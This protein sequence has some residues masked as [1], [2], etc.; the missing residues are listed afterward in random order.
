MQP[1]TARK[2]G[3]RKSSGNPFDSWRRERD[4]NPC[5]HSCITRFRIVR[6]RP[7]RHL[8]IV[9][10]IYYPKKKSNSFLYIFQRNSLYNG[11]VSIQSDF[12]NFSLPFNNSENKKAFTKSEG[13]F[14][15]SLNKIEFRVTIIQSYHHFA[16]R[17]IQTLPSYRLRK[18]YKFK[19][20]TL[21][22]AALPPHPLHWLFVG[23]GEVLRP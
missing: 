4:L 12:I 22:C 3:F 19:T 2:K 14:K 11:R 21:L 18:K 23:Y 17:T 20:P 8:C 9:S 7:L 6:V 1:K 16:S 5:M 15:S 10:I 13:F